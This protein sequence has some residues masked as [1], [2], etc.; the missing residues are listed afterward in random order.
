MELKTRTFPSPELLSRTFAAEFLNDVGK[1]LHSQPMATIALAGGSTPREIYREWSR[2]ERALWERVHI[3]WGDERCVPPD[4]AESNFRSAEESFL[5]PLG[6]TGITVHRLKGESDPYDE[7]RRYELEIMNCVIPAAN[8]IPSFDWILLG[9][10]ADGHT[11]SLFPGSSSLDE[12]HAF[13]IPARHPVS[14]RQRITMTLP[15]LNNARRISFLVTGKEK[16]PMIR[17]LQQ[18]AQPT[19]SIPASLIRPLH[20]KVEWWLD[21]SAL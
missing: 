21:Q 11:A 2:S 14:H 16:S 13:C 7:A 8:G 1:L 12:L 20:G 3:F 17:Q 10:G 5:T 18:L 4:N 19:T 6:I 15:L 9:L